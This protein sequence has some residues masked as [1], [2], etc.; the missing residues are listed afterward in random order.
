MSKP[1]PRRASTPR[2]SCSAAQLQRR[3]AKAARQVL[4]STDHH[5][6]PPADL[7]N[8][9]FAGDYDARPDCTAPVDTAFTAA[10]GDSLWA[11]LHPNW[12]DTACKAVWTPV[13]I[14]DWVTI[15]SR[16]AGTQDPPVPRTCALVAERR[17]ANA[18]PYLRV[19]GRKKTLLV[20]CS[21]LRVEIRQS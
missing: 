6:I 11:L 9:P 19:F 4:R 8:G 5:Q 2:S 14:I 7:R 1:N 3:I 17:V 15:R 10:L 21:L 18:S 16:A 13:K 20:C 12:T